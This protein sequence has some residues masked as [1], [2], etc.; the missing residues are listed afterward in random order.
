MEGDGGREKERRKGGR[1]FTAFSNRERIYSGFMKLNV[2]KKESSP[3]PFMASE[4]LFARRC[5]KGSSKS[6]DMCKM[7]WTTRENERKRARK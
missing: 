5:H 4:C 2:A 6:A 3:T 1:A 7:K